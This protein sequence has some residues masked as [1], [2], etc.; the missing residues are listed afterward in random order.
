[1]RTRIKRNKTQQS[2]APTKASHMAQ[3]EW[4]SSPILLTLIIAFF[5][6]TL[7]SYSSPLYPFNIWV[8]PNCFFTVGKSILDGIV[9][10]RDLYEQK[11]PLLYF[12]HTIAALISYRSFIGVYFME[13]IAAWAFLLIS[14]KTISL[15]N[16]SKYLLFYVL[17][18]SVITYSS[19]CF[20]YGDSAEEFCLPLIA[21]ALYLGFK[22]IKQ[23]VPITTSQAIILG[24]T[25]SC[26]FWIKFSFTGFYIGW[27]IY[28]LYFY[29]KNKWSKKIVPTFLYAIIGLIIP[30]IP[31]FIYFISNNAFDALFQTYFYDNTTLYGNTSPS[32]TTTIGII[33]KNISTSFINNPLLW[34]LILCSLIYASRNVRVFFIAT[35]LITI[36]FIFF[37]TTHLYLPFIL[38]AFTS[39]G[40]IAFDSLIKYSR[41][42]IHHSFIILLILGCSFY[43]CYD[44]FIFSPKEEL[45]HHKFDQIIKQESN[46]TLLNY[47]FLDGGFFTYSGLTPSNRFFC[48]LNLNNPQIMAEQDSI[49]NNGLATFI[50]TQRYANSREKRSFD[51]YTKVAECVIKKSRENTSLKYSLYKLNSTT[52]SK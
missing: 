20:V 1:M 36:V 38:A 8:D 45:P 28:L 29:L 17:V 31:I 50:V 48:K 13:I 44:S 23:L 19:Q 27:I 51:K 39:L 52:H 24:I 2:Q 49:A 15:F 22:T 35:L 9:P 14:H 34:I 42:I 40:V 5:T 7:F 32:L 12:L 43:S 21:Y 6:I 18:L 11:G 25:A 41:P 4:F 47:G 46:P 10:Y 16:N 33:L 37:R 30:T 3:K 26:I